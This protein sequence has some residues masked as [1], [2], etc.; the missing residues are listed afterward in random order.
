MSG[1]GPLGG[2]RI[3]EVEG[4]GGSPFAGMVLA[5]LG[6]E[7][8][9]IERPGAKADAI[10]GTDPGPVM[11]RGRLATIQLN[12]KSEVGLGVLFELLKRADVLT[13][14]FR[15]GVAERLGFGPGE[16]CRHNPRLI[17]ARLTGWGRDGPLAKTAGHDI[18]FIGMAGLLGAIGRPEQPPAPPLAI[19]GDMGGGG[20][21]L[22]LGIVSALY[23]RERSGLGQVVDAAMVD[24]AALLSSAF[25]GYF[26]KGQWSAQRGTNITD[27]GA[28][29]YDAYRCKDGQFVAVGALEPAFFRQLCII[30]GIE[31]HPR[32]QEREHWNELRQQLTG[33][34]LTRT[35]DEWCALAGESDACLSPVLDF[36]SAP[37]HPQNLARN[38]FVELGGITQ[39][40]ASP[41]FS[42]T[43]TAARPAQQETSHAV[44][45]TWGVPDAALAALG[46]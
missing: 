22:A 10:T 11:G 19:G 24:G 23:E 20:L 37:Q 15:P 40:S 16:A 29:F 31:Y 2:V 18:N 44:L 42:R 7:I 8:I 35:R 28:P 1:N 36:S 34:F 27:G 4:M 12:L 46:P 6:A 43:K 3:V 30:V 17:Y 13:E 38:T 41:H 9:R 32:L 39:P 26:G 33:I 45:R 21:F 14:A 5:D 25:W